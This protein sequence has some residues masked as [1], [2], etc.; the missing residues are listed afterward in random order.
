MR[1]QFGKEYLDDFEVRMPEPVKQDAINGSL[2]R[3]H[4]DSMIKNCNVK[5][6]LTLGWIATTADELG[7]GIAEK[8]MRDLGAWRDFAPI[9]I[10]ED[11]GYNIVSVEQE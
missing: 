4:Y 10:R 6:V 8:V 2:S 1:D 3:I 7:E 11:G 5:H 9:E